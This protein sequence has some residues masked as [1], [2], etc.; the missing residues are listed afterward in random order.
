MVVPLLEVLDFCDTARTTAKR[1]VTSVA[2]QALSLFN[3]EFVN[4]QAAHLANRLEKEAGKDPDKQI[5]R[6]YSLAL[7]RSPEPK[8]RA[9]MLAFLEREAE[10]RTKETAEKGN[11]IAP[12]AARHDALVQLC[13]VI[14]NLNEFVYPD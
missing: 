2:P 3:G 11:A 1:N 6:A 4:R 10:K 5:V 8:E 9:A 7:C 14:F 13:R 12:D